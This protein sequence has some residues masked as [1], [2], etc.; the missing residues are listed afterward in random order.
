VFDPFFTTK[1]NGR[2]LG[3]ASL[4]GILRGHSG[5]VRVKS[6]AGQGTVFQLLLPPDEGG[7]VK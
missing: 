3:L 2:G 7:A 1:S 5:D 4:P 6:R